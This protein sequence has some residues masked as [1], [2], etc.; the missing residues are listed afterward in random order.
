MEAGRLA[1]NTGTMP[2]AMTKRSTAAIQASRPSWSDIWNI[3]LA[4]KVTGSENR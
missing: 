1:R 4:C 2:Q 3:Q